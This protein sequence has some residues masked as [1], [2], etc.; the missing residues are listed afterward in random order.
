VKHLIMGTA[1]HVDHGKTALVRA[2]TGIDCDTHREEKARG[3]TINLGFAHIELASGESVGIV[4]VP[5]HRD[6]VNTMVA[7]ASGIDFVLLVVAADDGIMPQTREHL[8]IMSLLGIRSGLVALTKTDLVEDDLV[9]MAAEEIRELVAGTFL[10]GSRIVPVSSVSGQGL[11]ELKEAIGAVAS[12]LEDR[13]ASEVFRMF[14]DR[15][16]TVEGFGTVVTGSVLGG[17]LRAEQEAY[18]CPGGKKLRV[19]RLERHGEAV[20]EVRGGDRASV[21]LAGLDR[22]DY[23]RGMLVSDRP[24]GA[25]GMVDARLRLFPQRRDVKLWSQV[26]FHLGT[27]EHQARVHLMDCDR[28]TGGQTALVQVV[29]EEPCVVL[30]GDRFVIRSSSSDVTLGG[31]QVI[32]PRPLHHRRRPQRL[33]KEMAR[34]AEGRLPE[35]AAAEIRKR[36]RPVSCR[37][38]ADV[39][40]V[41]ASR[42]REVLGEGTPEDIVSYSSGDELYLLVRDQ[43]ARLR[44]KLL[45]TLGSYHRR[46]PLREGGRTAEELCG[47]VGLEGDPAAAAA[48]GLMLAEMAAEG[49]VKQVGRTWALARHSVDPGPELAGHVAFVEGFLRDSRMQTPLLSDLERAA[50]GRGIEGWELDEILRYLVRRGRAYFAEGNYLHAS[51]VDRSRTMLLEEL[52]RRGRGMTVAEFRDLVSGN[53]RICLLLLGLFDAE[54]VTSREGDLRVL[55]E[56]GRA[57]RSGQG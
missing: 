25:T 36:Y 57:A 11:E 6:F 53:R 28:L 9:E 31:G 54:G 1:G 8:Q 30:Y 23:R 42:L 51:V 20:E 34:L 4:D 26:I 37:E 24:L 47:L 44:E 7:G 21:N 56:K 41:G 14:V 52:A 18:L 16:F 13:P 2:L 46:H 55:T 43:D 38:L 32:D 19:R 50:R 45:T 40:N 15:I 29:L 3:I 5:G 48:L 10:E 33:V 39:L 27:Y 35:L 22:S 49:R 12:G 17:A